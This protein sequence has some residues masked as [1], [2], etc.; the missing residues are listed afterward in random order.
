M[1]L[2][3]ERER[4]DSELRS[5]TAAL[6]AL[7]VTV[8]LRGDGRRGKQTDLSERAKRLLDTREHVTVTEAAESLGT[9]AAY[10]STVLGR[11][12]KRVSR[13]V[14]RRKK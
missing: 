14:Y 12:G 11:V 9:S 2:A 1:K 4:I 3:A 6:T 10:A 13:G 8:A 5:L 7:D